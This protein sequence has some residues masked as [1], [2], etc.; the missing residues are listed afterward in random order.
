MSAL[1]LLALALPLVVV[2]A[3]AAGARAETAGSRAAAPAAGFGA[4]GLAAGD[5]PPAPDP[6]TQ[7]LRDGCQRNLET[8]IS[9]DA[10]EWAYVYDG[11]TLPSD[12]TPAPRWASGTVRSGSPLYLATHPSGG[13]LPTEHAAHDFNINL[14]LDPGYAYL[15]AGHPAAGG[16]PANGNYAGN[17]EGTRRLHTEL[18]DLTL[19]RF[20]WAQAGDHVTELGSW[21]WDCGHYGTPTN[22]TS[23]DYLLPKFGEPCL[24]AFGASGPVQPDPFPS[25]L[26]PSQCTPTGE[27][28]EFHPYRVLWDVRAASPRAPGGEQEGDLLISTDQTVAGAAADCNHSLR[29]AV[30]GGFNPQFKNCVTGVGSPGWQDVS[31]DYSFLLPA[32]ARPSATARLTYRAVDQ[33]SAGAAAPTLAPEGDAVRVTFHASTPAATR[34]RLVLAYSIFAGWSEVPAATVPAHLRV[35][36]QQ[37][38]IH[39]SMDAPDCRSP[40]PVMCAVQSTRSNQLSYPPGEWNLYYDVGGIWGQIVPASQVGASHCPAPV[41]ALNAN[42]GEIRPCDE[43][44]YALA[45]VVDLYL[46][47]GR[48]FGLT[49]LGR[50]C[51]Y[52]RS[53]GVMGDCPDNVGEIADDSDVPGAILD[54]FATA[55]AALGT[56]VSDGLVSGGKDPTSTCPAGSANPH[57][58]YTLTYAVALVDD[59]AARTVLPPP[60]PNTRTEGPPPPAGVGFAIIGLAAGALLTVTIRRRR[61]RG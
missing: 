18:E 6:I 47:P 39:R 2:P 27:Q 34:P 4:A 16:Q 57:G 58:C 41:P 40:H 30:A 21:V 26:D 17:D 31:G 13:D 48:S 9:G 1:G 60:L 61:S 52:G 49:T 37:L 44:T 45:Q 53:F 10:P 25:V 54:S 14:D 5:T 46:P 3:D 50:D 22:I 35:S 32:P 15:L 8:L 29:A 12:P 36:L 23:P 43:D 19:P 24:G 56:H 59:A 7:P 11:N 20:M 38:V 51:D 28:T 55:A 42:P 33:G